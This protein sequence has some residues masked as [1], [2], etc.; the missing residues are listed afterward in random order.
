MTSDRFARC[1]RATLGKL[2]PLLFRT[3][4]I[5]ATR[6]PAGGALLAGNHVSYLDPVLLWCVSPRPVHFMAKSELFVKGFIAWLLPRLWSFP[7]NRGEPD[8]TAILTATESLNSGGLVGVFPEGSRR[9]A[10]AGEAVGAAH[11]G[12]AFIALRAGVPIVPVA[13]LGTER[14]MPRGASLP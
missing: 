2:V 10:D 9:E 14:A 11:G 6:I 13:I 1:V 12:A 3:R 4:I 5:G 7:V 8:R